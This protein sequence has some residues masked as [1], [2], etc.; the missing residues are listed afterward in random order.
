M[1]YGKYLWDKKIANGV[2]NTPNNTKIQVEE[3]FHTACFSPA[4]HTFIKSIKKVNF[5]T[6]PGLN[7]EQ[8]SRNL[9]TP[10]ATIKGHLDQ[11]KNSTKTNEAIRDRANVVIPLIVDPTY[12]IYSDLPGQFTTKSPKGNQYILVLYHYDSNKILT[13]PMKNRTKAE[14]V[15]SYEKLSNYLI[16]RGIQP[17]FQILDNESSQE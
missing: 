9:D 14:I 5:A 12:K 13:E 6:W 16:D 11:K 1:V 2:I 4:Q 3:Y 8:I 15:R 7:P 10:E 17:K